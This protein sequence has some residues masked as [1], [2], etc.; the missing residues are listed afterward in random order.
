MVRRPQAVELLRWLLVASVALPVLLLAAVGWFTYQAA[1]I[2]ARHELTWTTEVAR[3]HAAK[4]FDSYELVADRVSDLLGT[5]DTDAVLQA[6]DH[7]SRQFRAMVADLPQIASLIVLDGTGHLLAA[8]EASPV[9]RATDFSDRDYFAALR[10]GQART[11]ISRV[12]ESRIT[13]KAFFGWG[14]ARKDA[15]GAFAGVIDIAAAP[16]FLQGFYAT[17]VSEIGQSPEGRIVTMIREDGQVL[18][19]YP[20]PAGAL[21]MMPQSNPFFAALRISPDK[22]LYTGQSVSEKGAPERLYAFR[23]VPGHP[24]YIVAGRSTAIIRA[25]WAFGMLR[26]LAVG[27]PAAAALVLVTL[28]TLRG[29]RR[30][31]DAL[32][33]VRAEMNRR[34]AAEAQLRQAQKMEAIG[35]LT[36]GIAH[37]FN[38]LLTVLRASVDL[39]RRPGLPEARRE[40]YVAAIADTT[41]RATRLTGQLLA[42]ARRQ[43]LKP[44]VF[45]VTAGVGG[46]VDMVRTLVGPRITV[47]IRQKGGPLHVDADPS[48]FDVCLVNL[49]VNARDAMGGQGRLIVAAEPVDAVPARDGRPALPGAHVAVSVIDTGVGIPADQLDAIF[50]PFFT[51]KPKGEGT[52]LGLSQAFG[53]VRQSGGEIVVDSEPGRGTTFTLYLPRVAAPARSAVA[54]APESAAPDLQGS[55]ALVVEDDPAVGAAATEALA[56]LGYAFVLT[57]NGHE[58]LAELDRDPER[59]DV[60]FSDVVMPGMGGIELGQEVRRRYADLP[61]VLTSGY[62]EVLARNGTFGFDLLHK[63]YSLEQLSRALAK[64]ARWRRDRRR[65]RA[66]AAAG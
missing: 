57:G 5:L 58:A 42:F 32:A 23:K 2:D 51:T 48:Q 66:T 60:V 30:E 50:E 1:F 22:G 27:V 20:A 37:D 29:A 15:D 34:E 61:V 47:E 36:G 9:N 17:L 10:D 44:E 55:F 16:A 59:F 40:R 13:G 64:A 46:V 63:P 52:G 43:A 11:F 45:D 28:A 8:T 53:F 49:A 33:Q 14:R 39:L 21:P 3:E 62:S 54:A 7:F 4:V 24:V 31:R 12:Q 65:L 6:E 25:E 41:E 19:R 35:R 26:A 38:N 56:E 18:A